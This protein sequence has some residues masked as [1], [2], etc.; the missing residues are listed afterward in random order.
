MVI[1][2]LDLF[3]WSMLLLFFVAYCL[4][5]LTAP[6]LL[7]RL[8]IDSDTKFILLVMLLISFYWCIG[9]WVLNQIRW[10]LV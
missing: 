4:A 10:V 8:K 9:V 6:L 5:F 1:L 3:S 2:G 7:S